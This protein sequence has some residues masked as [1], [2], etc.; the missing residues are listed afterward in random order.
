MGTK[1][2]VWKALGI[3]CKTFEGK[4]IV[5]FEYAWFLCGAFACV[6]VWVLVSVYLRACAFVWVFE[7][8]FVQ[9]M[10]ESTSRVMRVNVLES[11]Q[12]WMWMC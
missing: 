6:L 4:N 12:F 10:S 1:L 7:D 2:E 5:Q 11:V 3:R 9:W 8:T